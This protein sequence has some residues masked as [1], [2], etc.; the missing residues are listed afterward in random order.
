MVSKLK[1]YFLSAWLE[2]FCETSCDQ[3]MRGC[4]AHCESCCFMWKPS[5]KIRAILSQLKKEER[6]VFC[7]LHMY[8]CPCSNLF[9]LSV[10][11]VDNWCWSIF[12][13]LHYQ[14]RNSQLLFFFFFLSEVENTVSVLVIKWSTWETPHPALSPHPALVPYHHLCCVNWT[15]T[16]TILKEVLDEYNFITHPEWLYVTGYEKRDHIVHFLNSHFKT[17]TTWKV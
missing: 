15:L 12:G 14:I 16:F 17:F 1:P 11:L 5:W 6:K 3:A 7:I 13:R 4:T 9:T 8:I 10:K 2:V